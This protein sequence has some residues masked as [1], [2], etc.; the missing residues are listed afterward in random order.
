MHSNKSKRISIKEILESLRAIFDLEKCSTYDVALKFKE[1]ENYRHNFAASIPSVV[2]VCADNTM[3]IS[4]IS[5]PLK[6]IT[7]SVN[8]QLLFGCT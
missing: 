2:Y 8:S 7:D 1:M 3:H 6:V 5:L 4:H